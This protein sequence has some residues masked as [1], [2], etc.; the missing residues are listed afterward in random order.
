M[1]L[2]QAGEDVVLDAVGEKGVLLIVAEIFEWEN[3]D[4]FL[5]CGRR[6]FIGVESL[7]NENRDG[8]DQ[9]ADNQGVQLLS[10]MTDNLRR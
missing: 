3:R 10:R 1:N 6:R 7:V 2:R 5:G 4:A 9:N 8:A